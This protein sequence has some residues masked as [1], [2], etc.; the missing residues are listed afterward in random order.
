MKYLIKS[1]SAI[2]L[3]TIL[4]TS[5]PIVSSAKTYSDVSSSHWAY[6][7]IHDVTDQG[8]LDTGSSQFSPNM[9]VTRGEAVKALYQLV[10]ARPVNI[11]IPYTDVGSDYATYVKWAHSKGIT[12][13]VSETSFAPSNNVTKQDMCVLIL[14]TYNAYNVTFT[15]ARPYANFGDQTSI[16][17][18]ATSAVKKLFRQYIVNGDNHNNFNPRSNITRAMFA[19]MLHQLYEYNYFCS[20]TPVKTRVGW[21]WCW[22]ASAAMVGSYGVMNQPMPENEIVYEI[23]GIEENTNGTLAEI[24]AAARL[25]SNNTKRFV[26]SYSELS[27]GQVW[28][29]IKRNNPI[30]SYGEKTSSPYTNHTMVVLGYSYT[31]TDIYV[32]YCNPTYGIIQKEVYEDFVDGSG[33]GYRW[34]ETV[35]KET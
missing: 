6:N 19:V 11:T 31:D 8:I 7:A 4:I 14:N 9:Y 10:H 25:A 2:I 22:A 30:I 34:D 28:S 24:A 15:E 33:T 17:S 13:G 5:V 20:V 18:Y 29:K 12:H 16:S 3:L 21:N 23:K 26:I 32:H 1:I 27:A 35:I